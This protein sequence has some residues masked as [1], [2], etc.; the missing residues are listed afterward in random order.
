MSDTE[1]LDFLEAQFAGKFRNSIFL[2]HEREVFPGCKRMINMD[3]RSQPN[4]FHRA[5]TV[6]GA[7]RLAIAHAKDEEQPQAGRCD[8]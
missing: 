1:L 2:A 3:M 5:K 4:T 8:Q 7:I 6:R